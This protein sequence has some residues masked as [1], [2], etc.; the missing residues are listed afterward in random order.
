[1]TE[2]CPICGKED[3]AGLENH[4]WK[5][6]GIHKSQI[7]SIKKIEKKEEKKVIKE[8]VKPKKA[9]RKVKE[10]KKSKKALGG[11]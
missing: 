7:G 5:S 8:E 3:P 4:M 10:K 11:N 1:M 6:H 2:K 9:K